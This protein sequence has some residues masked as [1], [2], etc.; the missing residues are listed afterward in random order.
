MRVKISQWQRKGEKES[1][2]SYDRGRK[3]DRGG[4][5]APCFSV[6]K[7]SQGF[8]LRVIHLEDMIESQLLLI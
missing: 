3:R 7:V 8:S 6:D 5:L 2:E 4:V 1:R